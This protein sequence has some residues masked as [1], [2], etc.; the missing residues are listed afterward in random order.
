[1]S[2]ANTVLNIFTRRGTGQ[3]R[4]WHEYIIPCPS[5]RATTPQQMTDPDT[6]EPAALWQRFAVPY[7]FPVAFTR[8][9]FSAANP[10]FVDA[11]ARLE[12]GRRHRLLV[13]VD[14]GVARALP[15]LAEEIVAYALAHPARLDLVAAPLIV[16]A[17]EPIKDGWNALA[18]LRDAV[19]RHGLDRHAVVVGIGGGALLDAVGLVAATA[20]RGIRHVR[21]PTTV[22]AQNDSGVGVKNG[23]NL[24]GQKNYLGTFAPPFAV[25][26]D[27]DFL[28]ALPARECRAGMAEAVK[29]ALIRDADFFAALER[30]AARLTRF[31]RTP[32][33]RLVRRCAELHLRQIA[34]GGDPFEQ[35]SARPLDFG[36]WAAHRL[37]TLSAHRLRHGEAV[38]IGIELDTRY[39]VLAGL[40]SDADAGR[41]RTLLDTLG[42]RLWDD[43]LEQ[44]APDGSRDV[45]SGLADFQAHLGGDLCITLLEAIGHGR[46]VAT[47]DH[48]LLDRA[49]D[50]MRRA[51]V[52]RETQRPSA[53]DR[54]DA[55]VP[56]RGEDFGRRAA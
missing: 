2:T 54:P 44:R 42:F 27:A 28:D 55:G 51:D 47:M 15:D 37:E 45:L 20:H 10:V 14:D 21:V 3:G 48:A 1:M 34:A 35:G 32:L 41:V 38:A 18:P 17:G 19:A 7:A 39:S 31:E 29:V 36:H 6:V 46:E 49:I 56:A 5:A 25:L 4:K 16:T 13:V 52:E 26:N 53:E 23:V 11:V 8:R 30:D 40:L 9:L 12:P 50:D 33:A 43:T 24:Y 22:L